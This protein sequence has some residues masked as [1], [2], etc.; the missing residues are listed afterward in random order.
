MRRKTKEV[1]TA[2]ELWW[3][4]IYEYSSRDQIGF[5]YVNWKLPGCHES[6]DWDYT[7]MSE[8]VHIPH[9]HKKW[10]EGKLIM[11]KELYAKINTN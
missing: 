8:F 5:G 9:V 7:Y 6:F 3:N 10:R 2:C 11:A 1:L 4:Q